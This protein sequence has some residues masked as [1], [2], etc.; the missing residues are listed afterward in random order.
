MNVGRKHYRTMI[1]V[2]GC[3]DDGIPAA[4]L[5]EPQDWDRDGE[6]WVA[7]AMR[8]QCNPMIPLQVILGGY[9]KPHNFR[10]T[11]DSVARTDR[12]RGRQTRYSRK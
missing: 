7:D 5:Y 10:Y 4:H 6:D 2:D 11:G 12:S 3:G 1:E 9:V 8:L